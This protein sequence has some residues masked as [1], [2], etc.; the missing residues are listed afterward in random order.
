MKLIIDSADTVALKHLLAYYPVSGVTTNPSILAAAGQAPFKVL[1]AIRDLLGPDKDL[2]V[3][4]TAREASG[5]V[6]DAH[7]IVQELGEATF[8][9]I[10]SV[11]EGFRAIK[12]LADEGIRITATAIYTPMQAYLA[13]EA[14]ASY[15]APYINR[16]DNMGMDGVATAQRTHTIF[17]ANNL[18]CQVLAASFKNSQQVLDLCTSGI[19]AVTLVPSV[20]EGLV[21]NAAIDATLDAFTHDFEHLVGAGKTMA[22]C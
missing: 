8:V 22:T 21:S 20:L 4:V 9:K 16:I 15:A 2:H 19:G 12:R 11:A 6:D 17:Q 14:G 1:H 18:S 13:A 5:M 7:R 3:Q 10:P